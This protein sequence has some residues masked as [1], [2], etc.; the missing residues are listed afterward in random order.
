MR[1]T[2]FPSA[3]ELDEI[4]VGPESVT[5]QRVSDVRLN[6]VVVYAL[7]LQV[8][9]PTV[10]AGVRDYSEFER[11][12]WT[13][14][15]RTVDYVTLLVYGGEQAVG[16]GR[17]LRELHKRFK[18]VRADGERYSAL[19]PTAYAW[20]H[21]TLIATYVAGHAHFGDPM[22]PR[23]T[24]RFYAEYRR[25]G[26]LIGVRERDLPPSWA[27]F[28]AYF[29]RM[30][31][32]ELVPNESV[33]RVLR[34]VRRVP[35]PAGAIPELLWRAIRLPAC[36]AL[37]LGGVG[38]MPSAL[39]RRLDIPWSWRDEARFRGLGVVSR[40]LGAV[41]PERMR[42]AGPAQLHS[43]RAEIERGPLGARRAT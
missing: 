33:E 27:G 30:I 13:R 39:R 11:R 18:G 37:W 17:R 42:V 15:M 16:A 20:V 8:A 1:P 43:R 40:S 12:P 9:H 41:M 6:L 28:C 3:A 2:L 19:E 21:A 36:E 35:P 24:E 23:E 4:L 29:E 34:A 31:T 32:E 25:L 38:P 10:A 5:W 7:L 22:S 26:R 14:L